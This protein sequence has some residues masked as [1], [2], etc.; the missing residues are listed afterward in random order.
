MTKTAGNLALEAC[1]NCPRIW[2]IIKEIKGNSMQYSGTSIEIFRRFL[3]LKGQAL[4]YRYRQIL[5][6]FIQKNSR[7][8]KEV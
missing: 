8:V 7:N 3:Y 1:S 6:R 2:K 5:Q 4:L